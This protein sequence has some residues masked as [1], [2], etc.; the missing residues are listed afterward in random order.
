MLPAVCSVDV[1]PATGNA[2]PEERCTA[3]VVV[4]MPVWSLYTLIAVLQ[5]ILSVT[6]RFNIHGR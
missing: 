6:G 4:L 2:Q 5:E 3:P 1:A